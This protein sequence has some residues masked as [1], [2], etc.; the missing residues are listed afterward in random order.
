MLINLLKEKR[1]CPFCHAY[2]KSIK[3]V[4]ASLAWL[5][6]GAEGGS[7]GKMVEEKKLKK[8][9]KPRFKKSEMRGG[10]PIKLFGKKFEKGT[11]VSAS[12]IKLLEKV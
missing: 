7:G 1:N 4:T 8:R 6:G 2:I 9:G 3:S 10:L 11:V 5:D 12:S